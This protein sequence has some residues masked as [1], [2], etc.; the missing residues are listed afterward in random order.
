MVDTGMTEKIN[1]VVYEDSIDFGMGYCRRV[2][3][4]G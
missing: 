1:N 3:R 4:N 2:R